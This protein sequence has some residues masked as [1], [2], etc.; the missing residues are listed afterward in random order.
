MTNQLNEVLTMINNKMNFFMIKECLA[1]I[2]FECK[3]FS[4]P[5]LKVEVESLLA[6]Q[7]LN[8][9]AASIIII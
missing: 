2:G 1:S 9:E 6:H 5:S 4:M 3:S 8:D 7:Q